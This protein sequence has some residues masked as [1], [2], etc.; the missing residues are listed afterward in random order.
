M[1]SINEFKTFYMKERGILQETAMNVEQ[2]AWAWGEYYHDQKLIELK[3]SIGRHIVV[4]GGT[5]AGRTNLAELIKKY[6]IDLIIVDEPEMEIIVPES[7][8]IERL[9]CH[10]DIKYLNRNIEDER[11]QKEQNRLR[12]KHHN[13]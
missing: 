9:K 6:S 4:G 12:S 8:P 7:I 3:D 2:F 10:E 1:K 11:Y 13:R 5:M